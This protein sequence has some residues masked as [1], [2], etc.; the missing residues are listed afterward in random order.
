MNV[1]L[2]FIIPFYGNANKELLNRCIK[3]IK[4]QGIKDSDYEIIIAN[5]N[6]R[7]LGGARNIGLSQAIG[8]YI[9]FIDADDYI[10]QDSLLK[11]LALIEIHEPDILSFGLRRVIINQSKLTLEKRFS[12]STYL[13]GAEYMN[14]HNFTGS[15]CRHIF[16]KEFI[17][18]F[19]FAENRY[20]EDEDFVAKAYCFAQKTIITDY[21]VYA[22]CCQQQSITSTQTKETQTKRIND[23]HAMLMRIDHLLKTEE[24]IS[25][26][27]QNALTRRLNFLTIDYIRQ[28]RRNKLSIMEIRTKIKE[29]VNDGLLPLP[30]KN[31]SWKYSITCKIIN[32]LIYL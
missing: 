23:F 25:Q 22:Y 15:A 14:S 16:R 24:L 7:G 19:R 10:F 12:Y 3:S 20:H 8:K 4:N 1:K 17:S 28:L 32:T 18:S 5:D 29:L 31:Y 30:D 2:S 26:I 6:G 27:S 13:A 11:C 9:I 21:P